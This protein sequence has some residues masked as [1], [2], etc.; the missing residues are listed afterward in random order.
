MSGE[1]QYINE[2]DKSTLARMFVE[3]RGRD[4]AVGAEIM[5]RVVQKA[6]L[7]PDEWLDRT[8]IAR[9]GAPVVNE[10]GQEIKVS[11]YLCDVAVKH[12]GAVKGILDFLLSDT[13]SPEY[14]SEQAAMAAVIRGRT[15]R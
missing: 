9:S 2:L 10:Y 4:Q 12:P 5:R 3:T 8:L 7:I 1:R 6:D 11:G 13:E 14:K 15:S